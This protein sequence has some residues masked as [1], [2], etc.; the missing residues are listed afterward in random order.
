MRLAAS[1]PTMSSLTSLT[2]DEA[3]GGAL[4]LGAG[5]VT[6]AAGGIT[7]SS[8]LGDLLAGR[9]GGS[10]DGPGIRSS[11]VAAELAA[12]L[13]RAIGW[14]A[15][16]DGSLTAAYGAPGDTNIDGV[17]DVLDAANFAAAGKFDSGSP[18]TWN[19]GDFTYDGMVDVLDAADFMSTNLFDA[20]PYAPQ[21]SSA[22]VAAVPEPGVAALGLIA[23]VAVAIH[24]GRRM[25]PGR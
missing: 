2:I 17:V 10:W 11:V 22:A 23:A 9:N 7:T 1:G 12:S 21:G 13:P 25:P 15:N 20:G 5:G 6:I 3:A 19:Q 8:F 14:I 16:G 4:D 18:A 24:A